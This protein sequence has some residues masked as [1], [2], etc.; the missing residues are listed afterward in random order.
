MSVL[1]LPICKEGGALYGIDLERGVCYRILV[2]TQHSRLRT[3]LSGGEPEILLLLERKSLVVEDG[4]ARIKPGKPR[5]EEITAK[6][7]RKLIL[8]TLHY[9]VWCEPRRRSP[10]KSFQLIKFVDPCYRRY[11]VITSKKCFCGGCEPR[12][13]TVSRFLAIRPLVV[14]IS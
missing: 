2:K 9:L 11:Y 8:E 14:M 4:R 1:L 6:E 3:S 12:S 5:Y 10:R 13:V 7:A